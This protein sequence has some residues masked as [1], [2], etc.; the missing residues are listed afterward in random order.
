MADTNMEAN[1]IADNK[2][3]LVAHSETQ[4]CARVVV[5]STAVIQIL[6]TSM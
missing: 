5:G 1:E 3:T 4:H 6:K 2:A